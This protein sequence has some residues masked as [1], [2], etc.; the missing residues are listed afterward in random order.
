M[1]AYG[2]VGHAGAEEED[3]C[4]SG[5][6]G[7]VLNDHQKLCQ[8]GLGATL[9]QHDTGGAMAAPMIAPHR[10]GPAP[11]PSVPSAPAAS[12]G[13]LAAAVA[14][15]STSSNAQHAARSLEGALPQKRQGQRFRT[16]RKLP[17]ELSS[18]SSSGAARRQPSV[19][20]S[21]SLR[22][23]VAQQPWQ[24][25][26][27]EMSPESSPA[28]LA[29]VFSEAS[30]DSCP[31]ASA[32]IS[33]ASSQRPV[34][35][36]DVARA[37]C[38]LA[39]RATAIQ[40][41]L[42]RQHSGVADV[43]RQHSGASDV[44]REVPEA[45][46]AVLHVPEAAP[47]TCPQQRPGVMPRP[48]SALGLQRH[49]SHVLETSG[50]GRTYL[51]PR[52][53]PQGGSAPAR[54]P[55]PRFAAAVLDCG[56]R[57]R[58]RSMHAGMV[59]VGGPGNLVAGSRAV[60]TVL[61]GSGERAAVAPEAP[62]HMH[63]RK[64][65]IMHAIQEHLIPARG[66]ARQM[67]C[68]G[69][70][71]Q[72]ATCLA[73]AQGNGGAKSEDG[74]LVAEGPHCTRMDAGGVVGNTL[75]SSSHVGRASAAQTLVPLNGVEG[76]VLGPRN[77]AARVALQGVPAHVLLP[78]AAAIAVSAVAAAPGGANALA[79]VGRGAVPHALASTGGELG[80]AVAGHSGR[81]DPA[82][83][84]AGSR[85]PLGTSAQG[86]SFQAVSATLDMLLLDACRTLGCAVPP[87]LYVRGDPIARAYYVSVPMEG[88]EGREDGGVPRLP[89]TWRLQPALVVTSAALDA[90]TQPELRALFGAMLTHAVSPCGAGVDLA[91]GAGPFGCAEALPGSRPGSGAELL[92]EL[93]RVAGGGDHVTRAPD[94]SRLH[95][96]HS[97]GGA[98][99]VPDRGLAA[100][101]AVAT[102]VAVAELAPEALGTLAAGWGHSEAAEMGAG[103]PLAA[104]RAAERRQLRPALRLARQLLRFAEDR[105]AMLVAQVRW[106]AIRRPSTMHDCDAPNARVLQW[107]L[108]PQR[109]PSQVEV[110]TS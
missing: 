88:G 25:S 76:V 23:A 73:R 93:E 59:V 40:S 2:L 28:A 42:R 46:T 97:H 75:V 87:L 49:E 83:G 10:S 52:T 72:R 79:S 78:P 95:V 50:D 56:Q 85:A 53:A 64:D 38:T 98:L 81:E 89:P 48:Q 47:P 39:E 16:V 26:S 21:S 24:V 13:S 70:G 8:D 68:V 63:G 66:G 86:Q 94:T 99:A 109:F 45:S 7:F 6:Q 14:V 32:G 71:D 9:T 3:S 82:A 36:T 105:G 35:R 57:S 110:S 96:H 30:I 19:Q 102:V 1:N 11:L 74:H 80:V 103:G 67:P 54:P 100:A 22:S 27:P 33:T 62:A 107:P 4:G 84:L 92:A 12:A 51:R 101:G 91:C 18:D 60:P 58:G 37:S 20:K 55:K 90:L 104:I 77:P 108:L 29:A 106:R 31:D 15:D 17:L 61:S 65:R 44:E 41:H 43:S 5:T 34:D 69:G